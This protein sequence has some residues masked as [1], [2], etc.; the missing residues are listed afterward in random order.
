MSSMSHR[1]E[2]RLCRVC[3]GYDVPHDGEGHVLFYYAFRRYAHARCMVEK[4]GKEKAL[5]MLHDWERPLFIKALRRPVT[6]G[7]PHPLVSLYE[8]TAGRKA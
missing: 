7:R 5:S 2:E 8:A 3:D 6:K 1:F 4:W